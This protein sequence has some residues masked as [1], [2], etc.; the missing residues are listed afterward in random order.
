MR[1]FL[2]LVCFCGGWTCSSFDRDRDAFSREVVNSIEV[3]AEWANPRPAFTR[4][5]RG[6]L[7][8]RD[9]LRPR[10]SEPNFPVPRS[11]TFPQ[12]HRGPRADE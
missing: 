5:P 8:S 12:Q 9:R 6:L 3:A 2:V 4:S 1:R 10:Q 11:A 7:L